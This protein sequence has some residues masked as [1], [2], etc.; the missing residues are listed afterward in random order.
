MS[1]NNVRSILMR[2]IHSNEFHA[3]SWHFHIR[4]LVQ[5]LSCILMTFGCIL[6]NLFLFFKCSRIILWDT[7]NM[8]EKNSKNNQNDYLRIWRNLNVTHHLIDRNF[9]FWVKE[10]KKKNIWKEKRRRIC[11]QIE[12]KT[13]PSVWDWF[14]NNNLIISNM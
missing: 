7:L 13:I 4:W 14:L 8:G 9:Y 5:C 11:E 10:M 12:L 6:N 1:V 2:I 3:C